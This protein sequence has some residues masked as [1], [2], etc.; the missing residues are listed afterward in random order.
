MP[1]ARRLDAPLGLSL[2]GA[3]RIGPVA[4]RARRRGMARD[5]GGTLARLPPGAMPRM[6]RATP[7]RLLRAGTVSW[8]PCG[9]ASARAPVWDGRTGTLFLVDIKGTGVWHWRPDDEPPSPS[10]VGEPIGFAVLDARSGHRSLLGLKSGL[11]RLDL[12]V[13]EHSRPSP[14]PEPEPCPATG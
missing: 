6:S 4:R 7:F 2:I 13:G 1:L 14:R 9:A 3:A 10:T 8:S 12:R 11:A 5:G